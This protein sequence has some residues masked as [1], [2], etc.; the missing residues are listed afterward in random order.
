MIY[1]PQCKIGASPVGAFF[2]SNKF[3]IPFKGILSFLIPSVKS[4]LSIIINNSFVFESPR[5]RTPDLL[6]N[7]TFSSHLHSVSA[8][9]GTAFHFLILI[10]FFRIIC[11]LF[12]FH[13]LS[14]FFHSVSAF[15]G[16]TFHLYT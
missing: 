11:M 3:E 8:F 6:S 10:H 5:Q 16:S 15:T 1:R 2:V 9:T 13:L 4:Y 12:W 14:F 7:N